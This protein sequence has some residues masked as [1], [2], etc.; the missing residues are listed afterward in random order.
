M[1]ISTGFWWSSGSGTLIV[2]PGIGIFGGGSNANSLTSTELYTYAN[3]SVVYG[4]NLTAAGSDAQGATGNYSQ[5]VWA[6]YSGSGN[7]G[8]SIYSYSPS[9]MVTGTSLTTNPVNGISG[10]GNAT[11]GVIGGG[12]YTASTNIYTYSNNTVVAGTSLSKSISCYIRNC[13]IWFI[14]GWRKQFASRPVKH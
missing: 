4:T 9:S 10:V 2:G 7:S 14:L 5:S 8:T 13:Y 6:A 11:L 3:N 1:L 12:N